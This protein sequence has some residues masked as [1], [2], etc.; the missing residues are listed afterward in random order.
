MVAHNVYQRLLKSRFSSDWKSRMRSHA[1]YIKLTLVWF[2]TALIYAVEVFVVGSVL[3][4]PRGVVSNSEFTIEI[5]VE[6]FCVVAKLMVLLIPSNM[7]KMLPGS[8]PS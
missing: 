2:A 8:G 6:N 3:N 4:E 1:Q 7:E 5:K